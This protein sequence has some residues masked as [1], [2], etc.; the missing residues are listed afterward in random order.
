MSLSVAS[1]IAIYFPAIH[2]RIVSR[3]TTLEYQSL[4]WGTTAVSNVLTFSL[5]F[6]AGRVFTVYLSTGYTNRIAVPIVLSV[7]E[8]VIYVILSAGTLFA[9]LRGGH[10]EVPIPKGVA[11]TLFKIS[12]GCL[13]C[14]CTPGKKS[15]E[16]LILFGLMNFIFHAIMDVISIAF[17]MFVDE[18]RAKAVTAT[19]L[20]AV[21]IVFTILFVCFLYFHLSILLQNKNPLKLFTF[22]ATTIIG[23]VGVTFILIMYMAV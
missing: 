10:S 19:V 21:F 12:F 7:Q 9:L 5:L 1:T 17:L 11:N 16:I 2:D 3:A 22:F 8:I 13:C 4:Y 6:L 20:Y 23:F 15:A 14:C 18:L